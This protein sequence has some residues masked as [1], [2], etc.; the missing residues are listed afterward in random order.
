MDYRLKFL[1]HSKEHKLYFSNKNSAGEPEYWISSMY[2]NQNMQ[3]SYF[4]GND[5]CLSTELYWKIL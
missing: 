2:C 4:W 5:D 1:D 3:N